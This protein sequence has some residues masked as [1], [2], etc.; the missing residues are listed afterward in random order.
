MED[1]KTDAKQVTAPFHEEVHT[2][3]CTHPQ[4]HTCTH[5]T[6]GSA[7]LGPNGTTRYLFQ[8]I[9]TLRKQ[10]VT[11]EHSKALPGSL[12]AWNLCRSKSMHEN[13]HIVVSNVWFLREWRP[14]FDL[15]S[16]REYQHQ[17][18]KNLTC[19]TAAHE[20]WTVV[21]ELPREKAL[22]PWH[23]FCD[24]P[25]KMQNHRQ[26]GPD[27]YNWIARLQVCHQSAQRTQTK[28]HWYKKCHHTRHMHT[29]LPKSRLGTTNNQRNSQKTKK[30]KNRF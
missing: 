5:R 25:S 14:H 23:Q 2:Q 28:A 3:S 27:S 11:T 10:F 17:N 6:H 12:S 9:N 4:G 13:T 21:C 24:L 16:T 29:H 7:T 30:S 15:C 19:L 20:M 18:P 1:R 22:W 26:L 8:L